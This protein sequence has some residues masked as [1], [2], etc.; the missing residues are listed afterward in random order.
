[1][2]LMRAAPKSVYM[3][4]VFLPACSS[5]NSMRTASALSLHHRGMN[6]L[7]MIEESVQ[8][9]DPNQCTRAGLKMPLCMP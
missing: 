7:K 9:A 8:S 5:F 1:M 4:V 2:N 3:Q 6:L